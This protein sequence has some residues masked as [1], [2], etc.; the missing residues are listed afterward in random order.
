MVTG[1][2]GIPSKNIIKE[3]KY[4]RKAAVA[5]D[6]KQRVRHFIYRKLAYF[7]ERKHMKEFMSS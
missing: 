2:R 4:F 3:F 1:C 5:F 6:K 7:Y